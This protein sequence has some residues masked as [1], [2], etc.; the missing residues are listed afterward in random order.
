[1]TP[2]SMA[3][4]PHAVLVPFPAQG[5][6]NPFLKL[7]KLLHSKGF[8][9]TFVNTEYNHKRLLKSGDPNSLDGLPGF[10]FETIPE[11]LSTT[12][13]ANATQ[14]VPSLCQSTKNKCLAPFRE[15][16]HKLNHGPSSNGP[17]VTC[18]VSDGVMSFTLRASEELGIPN[19]VFWTTS[20][21]GFMGYK[22]CSN[23]MESGIIPFKDSNYIKDGCLETN[24]DWI[25]GKK[26]IRM[27]DL[28][29]LIR[30]TNPND[31]ILN[32]LHGEVEAASRASAIIL[33]TFDALERDVLDA[34]SS[35]FPCN[36]YAIGPLQLHLDQSK[37]SNLKHIG[38][39]LWKEDDYCVEW[40][41]SKDPKSVVYV[42]FGSVRVL[43]QEEII[44]LA[45]GLANSKRSFL[46]VI[47]P[48]LVEGGAEALPLDFIHETRESSLMARWCPQERVLNHP[49]IGGFLTH[50]GWNSTI[51]SISAGVP[52]V[53]WPFSSE[54][55]PNCLYACSEWG[56]GLGMD[57][58]GISRD[59]VEKLVRELMGG[60]KGK[61]MKD[62]AMEW[63]RKAQDATSPGGSS[64]LNLERLL[65]ETLQI[66]N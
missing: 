1:M 45:W 22:Q 9:I 21:C 37:E 18:I 66:K 50:C 43:T 63:K 42:N 2:T 47:R 60:E 44:E 5:H 52:M 26:R 19:V 13:D 46:W 10:R 11:G 32:F 57:G 20:A 14:P 49:S 51:E 28:P 53:C 6:I 24:V 59:E 36:I 64:Y 55:R 25:R 31:I 7:A 4:K 56:I 8:H 35:M 41:D 62:K 58:D 54:Q 34:L 38:S 15:L 29:I 23:L 65:Y 33:H 30:T 39:S 16:L 61:M 3:E 12:G 40:L 17:P 48:D 27:K